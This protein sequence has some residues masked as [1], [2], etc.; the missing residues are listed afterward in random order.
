MKIRFP[1]QFR[2]TPALKLYL[3]YSF[4]GIIAAMIIVLSL[5]SS[6]LSSSNRDL[7]G[8]L[9]KGRLR[10]GN[11][12]TNL[13]AAQEQ[14]TNLQQQDQVKLNKDLNAELTQIKTSY[15]LAANTYGEILQ[16]QESNQTKTQ[17]NTMFTRTLVLLADENYSSASSVLASISAIIQ[18]ENQKALESVPKVSVNVPTSNAP[19]QGGY[20]RQQV[21]TDSGSF[22]VDIVSADISSTKVIIDTA[23][24]S[25]CANNCPRFPLA[26]Y[27]ARSGAYAGVNGA[28]YCPPEYPQCAGKTNS[29]DLLIM[30]KNKYYFNSANNVFS[31]NPAAIFAPS[32]VRFVAHALEWGRD[33]SVDG[34]ISNFP[35]LVFN[36]SIAFTDSSDVKLTVRSNRSFVSNIGN[37]VFIG[38]VY[39]A[40]VADSARVMKA[41]GFTNAIN[42]DSGGSTAFWYGG[43]KTGPGRDLTN[44][45]LFVK[46]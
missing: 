23:A 30:N 18:A 21:Q 10:E 27:I 19:P 1:H 45:I 38:V 46:R 9:Q 15:K 2:F 20:R 39:G 5:W 37:T 44:V 3:G 7:K 13:Q 41:L 12:T 14:L 35:L 43:Y 16:F 31:Q 11:L 36:G 24:D 26:T 40:T 4:V 28:Y 42:L 8:Q 6:L 22:M 25:D 34:V 32:Y 29:F 17:L 33:T